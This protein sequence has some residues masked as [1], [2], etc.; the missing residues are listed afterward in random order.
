MKAIRKL[1]IVLTVSELVY[2]GNFVSG[3][4]TTIEEID[5]SAYQLDS[6]RTIFDSAYEVN[7]GL[8]VRLSNDSIINLISCSKHKLP[9]F[10]QDEVIKAISYYPELFD[11]QVVFKFKRIK[12]TMNA[13]PD[14]LNLFRH[15]S[16]RK[17]LILI[18]NNE[19]RHKGLD[20]SKLSFNCLVGW[21]GHE[22]GHIMQYHEMNNWQ[23]LIF[24]IKY[25]TS[26]KC[27]VQTERNIDAMAIR[28]GLGLEIYEGEQI[29]QKDN[30]ISEKY[31]KR[32]ML[33]GLSDKVF[34]C[35]WYNVFL[36]KVL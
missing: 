16:S 12:G 8:S 17:Y 2:S 6:I 10:R 25:M 3:Q 24:S 29:I 31:K 34:I 4:D 21:Y 30:S 13:R 28:R 32:S 1:I 7:L 18:N 23:T 36:G 27:V 20:Y 35:L 11:D 19:G 5:C 9:K 33:N 15:R 14:V 26:V 22:L